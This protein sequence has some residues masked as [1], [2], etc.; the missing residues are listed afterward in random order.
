LIILDQDDKIRTSEEIDSI[1]SAEIPDPNNP[2]LKS[3]YN[4]VSACM[5]HTCGTRCLINGKCNKHFPKQFQDVTTTQNDGY[6]V[7]KRRNNGINITKN[8]KIYDNRNIVPYNPTLSMMYDCHI[9]VEICSSIKAVKYIY[10]Y[11]CKGTYFY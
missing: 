3:L 10:K 5:I 11:I 8:G 4:T 1:V 6:P 2:A 7:Y 9:N